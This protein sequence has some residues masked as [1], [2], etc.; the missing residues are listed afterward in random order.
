MI[1]TP[2]LFISM[3]LAAF[4]GLTAAACLEAPISLITPSEADYYVS[5]VSQLHDAVNSLTD[6]QS[7]LIEPGTYDLQSTLWISE[8]NV[9]IIGNSSTCDAVMLVG[10]GMENSN[11][12]GVPYGIW[13]NAEGLTV[14]NLTI[15]DTYS[16]SI[17][18]NHGAHNA[19]LYN[20][21]L[22]D[23]GEQFIKSNPT[24]IN[25]STYGNGNSNGLI[26]YS[27][28]TYT[29]MP[30]MDESHSGGTGYTNGID[31]HGGDAWT[32]RN[33]FFNNFHTPDEADHLWNAAVHIWNGSTDMV[34]KNNRFV[35]VDRAIAYGIFNR[36]L[37]DNGDQINEAEGGIIAN[38]MIYYRPGLF[39]ASRTAGSDAAIIVWS[40]PGTLV[41]HNTIVNNSNQGYAIESR[42]N[43]DIGVTITNNFTDD[44][45]DTGGDSASVSENNRAIL[46]VDI[47]AD[48]AI[49]DLHLTEDIDDSMYVELIDD[50]DEDFDGDLR[51][52][53]VNVYPGADQFINPPMPPEN[54]QMSVAEQKIPS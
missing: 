11:D 17:I 44:S 25:G 6:N 52:L 32:I 15:K 45:V 5:N 35:D 16:S 42:W 30:P 33:N 22:V 49:A 19:H 39:S 54:L 18:L 27:Y 14:K 4:S 46:S 21:G 36:G 26:E 10:N 51:S 47:F 29:D 41:A 43:G 9:S 2:T 40:S 1:K 24:S 31:V 53:S 50:A 12:G 28:F 23:A 8:S 20:L 3:S 38:N 13:T 37:D 34:V 7:I 48:V